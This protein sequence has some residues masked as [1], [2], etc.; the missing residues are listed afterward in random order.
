MCTSL[1]ITHSCTVLPDS[2]IQ[3]WQLVPPTTHFPHSLPQASQ[4][5]L[6]CMIWV[7]TSQRHSLSSFYSRQTRD[8]R[9]KLSLCPSTV[10]LRHFLPIGECVNICLLR[11]GTQVR[12][13][14]MPVLTPLTGKG[15]AAALLGWEGPF[16]S[17]K[18]ERAG[19]RNHARSSLPPKLCYE[20]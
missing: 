3:A 11:R 5:E 12:Q 13:E 14:A 6:S 18:S 4:G 20:R 9:K 10:L 16:P 1:Q 7:R 19:S 8:E 15:D 17:T 2:P